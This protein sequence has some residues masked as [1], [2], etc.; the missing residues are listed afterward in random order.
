MSQFLMV[1]LW[2]LFNW[3]PQRRF[4]LGLLILIFSITTS[5]VSDMMNVVSSNTAFTPIRNTFSL[6]VNLPLLEKVPKNNK[7]SFSLIWLLN[8]PELEK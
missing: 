6:I 8:E 1:T 5:S 3:I 2:V 7:V 4:V